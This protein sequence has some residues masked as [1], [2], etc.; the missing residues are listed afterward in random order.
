MIAQNILSGLRETEFIDTIMRHLPVY[1]SINQVDDL[2]DPST[3]RNIWANQAVYD[4]IGYTREEIDQL[5]VRYFL[6]TM[7]PDDLQIIGDAISK[8]QIGQE[9]LYSGLVRIK[10]RD[11]DFHWFM[12]S[13]VVLEWR[14][15]KPWRFL[16]ATL[17]IEQMQDTQLQLIALTKENLRLRNQL[18][19]NKLTRREVEVIKLIANSY[20]DGMIADKLF[21]SPATAKTH[22]NNIKQKLQLHNTAGITKFAFENGLN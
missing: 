1:M 18:R 3:N 17:D 9:K 8:F 12:G 10:P 19:I 13:I 21:I 7:H 14:N 11:K 2:L 22:R 5:G 16:I 4:F 15:D 6:E 20:T